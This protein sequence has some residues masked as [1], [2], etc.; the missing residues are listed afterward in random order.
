MEYI[1]QNVPYIAQPTGATCWNAAYKMMLKYRGKS[2][3][4]AD[5]L[6]NDALMRERG[7]LD[8]EFALCRQN[9]GLSSSTH[10]GFQ[11][12]DAIK[13]KLEMYGPIWVSGDYCEGRYKHILILRGIKDP[14]IGDAEVYVNDPYSGFRYGL[15][16]PRW[17][18]FKRFVE[19]MNKV[20]FA[21][22][23]WL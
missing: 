4:L 16:Q 14:L 15:I 9:L 11:T 3:S 17:L 2:E 20:P 7:I 6:P 13:T 23:H 10:T 21:C 1:V 8:R 12:V 22:Q 5:S 19:R 18:N